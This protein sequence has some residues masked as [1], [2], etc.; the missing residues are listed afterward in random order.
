DAHLL[1]HAE[2]RGTAFLTTVDLPPTRTPYLQRSRRERIAATRHLRRSGATD[3]DRWSV[4]ENLDRAWERR[5]V[6]AADLIA[7][8]SSVVD[9]GAGRQ[10]LARHL[11]AGATYTPADVVPRSPDTVIVDVNAGQFPD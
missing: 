10:A 11:P 4:G 2:S 3:L 8:G 5:V 6:A 1:R 9:L 7:P